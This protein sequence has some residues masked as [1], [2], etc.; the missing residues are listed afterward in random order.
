MFGKLSIMY[1]VTLN[2]VFSIILCN[3]LQTS[4]NRVYSPFAEFS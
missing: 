3:T 4:A 2:F 1:V